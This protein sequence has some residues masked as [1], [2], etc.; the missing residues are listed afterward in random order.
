VSYGM[1]GV[2]EMREIV[3]WVYNFSWEEDDE[4]RN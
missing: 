3:V 4:E 2:E 1:D